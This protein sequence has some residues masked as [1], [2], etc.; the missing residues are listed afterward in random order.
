MEIFKVNQLQ[1]YIIIL[2]FVSYILRCSTP[3]SY[4]NTKLAASKSS[5]E[6]TH[7]ETDIATTVSA[8]DG[9]VYK[10]CSPT[11]EIKMVGGE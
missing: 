11:E 8:S 4:S 10:H 7:L 1:D 6:K 9:L 3:S 5:T 2:E